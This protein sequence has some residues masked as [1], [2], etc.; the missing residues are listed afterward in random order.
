MGGL[1]I[2]LCWIHAL[3]V[4]QMA[5]C[6]LVPPPPYRTGMFSTPPPPQSKQCD[7]PPF[8]CAMFAFSDGKQMARRRPPL[9]V[10]YMVASR[11]AHIQTSTLD[12]PVHL[13]RSPLYTRAA[14][15]A[16]GRNTA[17]SLAACCAGTDL[18]P[19]CCDEIICPVGDVCAF[20]LD[21][22]DEPSKCCECCS[23]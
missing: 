17:G 14:D 23:R 7:A 19:G 3:A 13:W 18:T 5:A 6:A 22:D 15:T 16:A 2:A 20:D 12:L 1:A 8:P 10:G 9:P 4:A 11:H 21:T